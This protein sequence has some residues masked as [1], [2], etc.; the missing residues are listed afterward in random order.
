MPNTAAFLEKMNLFTQEP[1]HPLQTD[2]INNVYNPPII[3]RAVRYLHA[4]ASFPTKAMWIKSIY[5]VNYLSWPLINVQ[6][7]SKHSLSLNKHRK[8]TCATNDKGSGPSR[9]AKRNRQMTIKEKK[10][11]V[12][13]WI[14]HCGT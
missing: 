3:G 8:G 9:S 1:V 6:N 7:V 11:N 2:T 4:F 10:L 12:K 5:K 13:N 14:F